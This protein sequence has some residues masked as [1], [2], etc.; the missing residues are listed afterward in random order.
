MRSLRRLALTLALLL[1]GIPS[2]ASADDRRMRLRGAVLALG[3]VRTELVSDAV[4][5]ALIAETEDWSAEF[6]LAL[7]YQES[8]LEPGLNMRQR[9]G[10]ACGA[11][12]VSPRDLEENDA[13]CGGSFLYSRGCHLRAQD[14]CR[15]WSQDVTLAFQVGVR[16]LEWW[17]QRSGGHRSAALTGRACG[18]FKGC[19]KAWFIENVRCTEM[20]IRTGRPVCRYKQ[21]PTR[22]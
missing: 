9:A 3:D 22:S 19:G 1:P 20:R 13:F 6:L 10:Q 16:E 11:L 4:E 12:Q 21:P 7:A 2:P 8:R 5:A 15:M 14:Q 18:H 17:L